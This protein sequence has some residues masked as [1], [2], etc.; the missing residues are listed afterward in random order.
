MIITWRRATASDMGPGLSIEERVP[1]AAQIG[2]EAA[3][4]VWRNLADNQFFVSAVYEANP[5]IK[6]RRLIG[7][8]AAVFVSSQLAEREM[9]NL[10]TGAASRIIAGIEHGDPVLANRFDVAQANAGPGLDVFVLECMWHDEILNAAERQELLT[11][12]PASFAEV[13]TGYRIR[14]IVW[15]SMTTAEKEFAQ[16]SIVY[17]TVAEFP[18]LRR[19]IHVMDS[20]SVKEVPGSLGNVIFSYRE[21]KLRLR[22][23]D[24]EM[25]AA[26]VNGSTDTDLAR[27]LGVTVSAVK[28]RWRS[29]FTSIARSVP[30][31]VDDLD[32]G[33]G[34]GLQK[35][36]LV[37]AYV[38][39]HPEELRPFA[40]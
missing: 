17:R 9:G 38:R 26:A 2:G 30:L 36:H 12:I 10:Q 20:D 8:A 16:R 35:R 6:G 21:P 3:L 29:T 13:L 14:R 23:S 11:R 18:E 32:D 34:R 4:K 15:E 31:L 33:R 5:P 22:E 40:W 19:A 1:R 24:Q 7:F 27:E 37:L 39:D 25:L 28:A